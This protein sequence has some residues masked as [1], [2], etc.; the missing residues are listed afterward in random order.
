VLIANI[1]ECGYNGGFTLR[2]VKF[3]VSEGEILL[4]T[5]RSGSGKTTLV[6]AV[7]GTIRVVGGYLNG[8]VYLCNQSIWGIKSEDIYNCVVYIPQEPWY[9]ILGYTVYT[10]ICHVLALK[11][12]ICS[13]AEFNISGISHLADRLTY[14][15]SAGE[16]QRV[17]WAEVLLKKS[18]V[19]I[20]D[21][22]LVYLD[23]NAKMN[24]KSI[25]ERALKE[26]V[27]VLLVDHNPVFWEN[28]EPQLLH[29]RDGKVTY[30]GK[31]SHS[32]IEQFATNI[33][34]QHEIRTNRGI[35]AEL[36]NVWFKYP[37]GNYVLRNV[38]MTIEK[39]VLTAITGPNGSGK[40]TLL[41][42]ASGILKPSR[43][44][45]TRRGSAI[46]IPENPLL[47]FTKPTPREELLLA[48]RSDEFRALDI[49]EYFSIKSVL[50]QPL[51]KLSS[52]ERKRVALASAYLSGFDAYF[53]DEPTGG[54]D[55]ESAMVVLSGLRE[56]AERGKAVVIATHDERAV[57]SSDLLVELRA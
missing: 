22:P 30:Y 52:G 1:A 27:A 48:S 9:A 2:D 3:S 39:G 38:N 42:L 32:I 54:L 4:V 16:T 29:L 28:F 15:L 33:P 13:E 41:K 19:L 34:L 24:V 35:Y 25:I 10:E 45:I 21:E 23:K 56:L 5:G 50:D 14:T 40:T 8:E 47:Y 37:G 12:Y 46:Y 6:R 20:L 55:Y 26:D 17:L 18:R 11:G 44:V 57:K 49:A 43:G 31:W 51:A 36:K 53:V 7:M